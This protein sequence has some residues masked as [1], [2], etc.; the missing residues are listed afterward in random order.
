L[1]IDDLPAA[2][3]LLLMMGR[4]ALAENS[5]WLLLHR[6]RPIEVPLGG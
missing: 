3:L 6:Q 2:Q 1:E 4:Q 5:E